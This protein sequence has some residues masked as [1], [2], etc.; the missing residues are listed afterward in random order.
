MD[1]SGSYPLPKGTESSPHNGH[2]GAYIDPSGAVTETIAALAFSPVEP[3][4]LVS[5]CKSAV[6][7]PVVVVWD[8][9]SEPKRRA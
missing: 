9:T 7:G 8:I 5:G 1:V 6:D 3:N 2:V 4:I